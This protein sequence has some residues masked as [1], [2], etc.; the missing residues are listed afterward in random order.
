MGFVLSPWKRFNIVKDPVHVYIL[1][2]RDKLSFKEK[3][4]E[5]D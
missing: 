3:A 1:F 5:I 4:T 2:T